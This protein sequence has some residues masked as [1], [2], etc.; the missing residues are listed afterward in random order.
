MNLKPKEG[1]TI[2]Q[3]ECKCPSTHTDG[4]GE[5]CSVCN[6]TSKE[7]YVKNEDQKVDTTVRLG[8][9]TPTIE[10]LEVE[11]VRVKAEL[12]YYRNKVR[13]QS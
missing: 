12:E 10:Q 4:R 9:S 13:S 1:W 5:F 3:A 2:V 8:Q 7:H 11:L 6:E